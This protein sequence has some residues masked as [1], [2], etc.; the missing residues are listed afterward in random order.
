ARAAG[1]PTV[2]VLWSDVTRELPAGA[3]I[4][5]RRKRHEEKIAAALKEFSPRFLVMAGYM[6]ILTRHLIDLYRDPRGYTRIVNIH[7]SLLPAF[8]GVDA[9]RQAFEYGTKIAGATVHLVDVEVDGGPICAQEAFSIADCRSAEE[10]EK[11]GL[12]VE[13]RL[14]PETLRWV[15]T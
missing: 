4:E 14:F 11:R 12:A 8:P 7:P 3:P 1:I 2:L 5:Q 10:V 13:H 9:Y 15:L 6:R